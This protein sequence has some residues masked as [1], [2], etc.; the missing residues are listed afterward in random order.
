MSSFKV[1]IL[2]KDG[3]EFSFMREYDADTMMTELGYSKGE[4]TVSAG[5]FCIPLGE[6]VEVRLNRLAI[7]AK[8]EVHDGYVE[9]DGYILGVE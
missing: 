1:G 5:W 3:V 8:Y 2:E 7:T 4:A 6:E 9:H